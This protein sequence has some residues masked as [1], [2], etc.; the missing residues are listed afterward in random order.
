MRVLCSQFL[1][2][3]LFVE[4]M[5]REGCK[6]PNWQCCSVLV[7]HSNFKIGVLLEELSIDNKYFIYDKIH[8]LV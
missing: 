8:C 3:C 4:C 5:M 2:I 7:C 1:F 6:F